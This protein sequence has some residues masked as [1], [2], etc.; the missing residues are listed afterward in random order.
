MGQES[1]MYYGELVTT[2]HD[3]DQSSVQEEVEAMK[4]RARQKIEQAAYFLA[5]KRGFAP[6]YELE[7]WLRAEAQL[8][9]EGSK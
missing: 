9:E 1:G 4:A 3:E 7:D 2:P 8:K 5:E 6:G